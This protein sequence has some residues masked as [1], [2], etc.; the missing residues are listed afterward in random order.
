MAGLQGAGT[1]ASTV[2]VG[3]LAYDLSEQD[4]IDY[5][6]KIGPVKAIRIVTER[7][8]GKPRG[9]GFVE[10]YDIPTAESCIRNLNGADL[11]G[12]TIRIVFAEGGPG[13]FRPRD[14]F[15]RPD[16]DMRARRAASRTKLVGGDLAY[17]SSQ[18]MSVL[19]GQ[20]P[21]PNAPADQLTKMLA[22]KTRS[23]LYEYLAQMQSL[24][25]QNPQQARRMLVDNP[26]LAR[27]LFHMEIILG[28]VSNPMGD[29]A[30]KGVAPPGLLPIPP[31]R[32]GFDGGME[33]PPP[34]YGAPVPAPAPIDPRLA[35]AAAG[36]PPPMA[37]A[38]APIDPR[39]Q[40]QQQQQPMI[41]A[42]APVPMNAGPR[43]MVSVAVGGPPSVPGVVPGM[44]PD[45]QNALVQQVMSL[46]PQQ[47]E[48]L[49]PEQKAQVLALQQ[50]LRTQG[51]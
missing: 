18:G 16:V 19:L 38:A 14:D 44:N 9:F 23:E 33:Q 42:V 41:S 51:R 21:T 1:P 40:Q 36:G 10:F 32:Q 49:P 50:Q 20:D 13:D 3:N 47:I 8:S 12:R 48:L 35:V 7:E 37:A 30:P 17:H 46:T 6:S 28:M 34:H 2:F 15:Q 25:H 27:A 39:R 26:Q 11:N 31:Q 29:I 24:L 4:V 43:P 22:R 5:F 45:Q